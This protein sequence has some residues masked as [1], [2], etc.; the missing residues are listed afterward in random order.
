MSRPPLDS[1]P[2]GTTTTNEKKSDLDSTPVGTKMPN[3]KPLTRP[4]EPPKTQWKR[5]RTRRPR[6]IPIIV[7]LIIE[8]I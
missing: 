6:V 4:T 2:I 3:P 8:R 1:A 7:R 5:E